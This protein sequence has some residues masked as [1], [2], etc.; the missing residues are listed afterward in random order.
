[1]FR[2]RINPKPLHP[3][4]IWKLFTDLDHRQHGSPISHHH[5]DENG[6][7]SPPDYYTYMNFWGEE[8]DQPTELVDVQ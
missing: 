6:K 1:M 4:V 2:P 3:A 8:T 7:C 5:F